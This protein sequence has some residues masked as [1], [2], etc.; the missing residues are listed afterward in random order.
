MAHVTCA[1]SSEGVKTWP[2]P[3]SKFCDSVGGLNPPPPTNRTLPAIRYGSVAIEKSMKNV[4]NFHFSGKV[5]TLPVKLLGRCWRHWV[6][7]KWPSQV[8]LSTLGNKATLDCIHPNIYQVLNFQYHDRR[9]RNKSRRVCKDPTSPILR[10][11]RTMLLTPPRPHLWKVG[12]ISPSFYGSAI[13]VCNSRCDFVKCELK[14][15]LKSHKT[16][17]SLTTYI[18]WS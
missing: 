16:L 13:P 2:P 7:S 9:D 12:D 10:Y 5:T 6:Y 14:L 17:T 3:D 11:W 15:L 18:L 1:K 8:R 4:R